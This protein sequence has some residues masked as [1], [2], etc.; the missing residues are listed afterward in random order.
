MSKVSVI[1]PT[2]NRAYVLK[3]AIDSVFNQTYKDFEFIIVD[4]GSTD[5]TQELLKNYPTIKIITT[6][7]QGVSAARNQAIKS[8]RGEWVAF[9]DSDD[10]WLPEKLEKQIEYAK[11][12]PHIQIIHGEEIWI[13]N[14][15][16]VNPKTKHQK[17]GGDQF[18]PSLHLCAISPSVVML[19]KSL[20]LDNGMFRED[21]PCCEDYDLW[22][23][24]TAEHEV[25][26]IDDFLVNK[27]GG[28][29]D[30]LSAKFKAMD[31]WR[32]VS[33]DWVLKNKELIKQYEEAVLE[34][35]F[36]KCKILIKGYEKHGNT[37]E[38]YR[39]IKSIFEYHFS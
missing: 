6:K 1:L 21:Y 37:G 3:R 16:R 30:Q 10:E 32:V 31:Y 4:D 14:G 38:H 27:Y 28:H 9:I 11:N 22:L 17:G 23:K 35:I 19:K 33:L 13:R 2:F 8:A 12:H 7:N 39:E 29:E 24:I 34:V 18:L 20:L 25:G 15:V 5:D 36:N 26:F